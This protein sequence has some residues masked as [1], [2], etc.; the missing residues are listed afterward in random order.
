MVDRMKT[1]EEIMEEIL[2]MKLI[3]RNKGTLTMGRVSN[4]LTLSQISESLITITGIILN[5]FQ[6]FD[7]IQVYCTF[8]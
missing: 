2:E 1:S 8:K 4:K 6:S 5:Q 3:N 7:L